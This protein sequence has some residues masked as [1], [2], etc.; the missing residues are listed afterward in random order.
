MEITDKSS[1]VIEKLGHK[2]AEATCETAKT[3]ETCGKT[4][5]EALGH[6]WADA[7]CD[8]P[9]TCET[10]GKTEGEKLDHK[11]VDATCT[12]AKTCKL[13]GLT[14]G[15]ALGHGEVV[16]KSNKTSHW[17]A[18]SVCGERLSEKT[19]GHEDNDGDEKCDVCD[20]V[21]VKPGTP[22]TGDNTL[23]VLAFAMLLSLMGGSVILLSKKRRA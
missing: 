4:E 14:D 10:C 9:K 8:S 15:E 23:Y 18:C 7:T 16:L 13:C 17:D 22:Q 20:Y 2:W 19:Q 21:L 1:V 3:C 5:G 6:K 12:E 11:W